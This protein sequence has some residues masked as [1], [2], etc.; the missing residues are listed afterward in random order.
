MSCLDPRHRRGRG[1]EGVVQPEAFRDPLGDG[2]QVLVRPVC[3]YFDQWEQA[4]LVVEDGYSDLLLMKL[5]IKCQIISFTNCEL[6]ILVGKTKHRT[7]SVRFDVV[8]EDI[9]FAE[10]DSEVA[11]VLHFQPTSL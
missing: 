10:A 4:I 8:P 5:F 1:G 7:C 9:N 2:S 6:D 11:S 3:H